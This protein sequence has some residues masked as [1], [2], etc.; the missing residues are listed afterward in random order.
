[1]AKKKKVK[2]IRS[3]KVGSDFHNIP[4]IRFGG[5]YLS[6]ELGL[7]SGDRV[8][9][10]HKGDLIMLRKFSAEEL[11]HYEANKQ[12]KDAKSLLKKLF[13]L[14]P[15]TQASSSMMM[16]AEGR[17]GYSVDHELLKQY[18]KFLQESKKQGAE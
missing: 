7:S 15:E 14:I 17:N 3:F 5:K 6:R 13:P 2:R 4:F 16:V 11:A 9:L 12:Q 1:M 10:I 18:E 8:Q